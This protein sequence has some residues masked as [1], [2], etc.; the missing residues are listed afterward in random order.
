[1]PRWIAL[2]LYRGLW[3]WPVLRGVSMVLVLFGFAGFA[4][5]SIV[6]GVVRARVCCDYNVGGGVFGS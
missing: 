6:C 5:G 2:R 4:W 3:H 1:V